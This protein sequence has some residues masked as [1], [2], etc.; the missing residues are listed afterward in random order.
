[1]NKQYAIPNL[2]GVESSSQLVVIAGNYHV[3]VVNIKCRTSA[4][5]EPVH[6]Y[7]LRVMDG[8]SAGKLI[9]ATISLLK[10]SKW[11]YKEFLEACN[12]SDVKIA[13]KLIGSQLR[14]RT[15]LDTFEGEERLKISRFLRVK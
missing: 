3:E 13:T 4:Q 2:E 10:N 9:I 7:T 8:V 5:K 15:K 6:V 14:V 11:R 1:M 12:K